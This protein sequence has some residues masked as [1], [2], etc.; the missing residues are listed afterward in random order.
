MEALLAAP[1]VATPLGLR[2]R[3][4]LETLYA[5]GLRVSELVGLT[6]A[7]VSLASGVV[8]VIGKGSKERLVPLGDEAAVWIERYLATARARDRRRFTRS[9]SVRHRA[10]HAADTAGVLGVDQAPCTRRRHR[11]GDAVAACAAPRVRDAPSEPRR[12]PARRAAAARPRR[13][14]DD[15]DLH[16]RRARAAESAARGRTIRAADARA[17]GRKP[18]L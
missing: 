6:H 13:H 15:D 1:D 5:T 11:A 14:H 7:Q 9:A 2:D 12:R 17:A 10:A 18:A 8:R 3:A 16:A 4:M